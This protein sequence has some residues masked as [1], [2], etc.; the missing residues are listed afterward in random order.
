MTHPY[1]NPAYAQNERDRDEIR[2]HN[3]NP[4][5]VGVL[6]KLRLPKMVSKYVPHQGERE[7]ARRQRQ[8]AR[9][10]A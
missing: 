1:E 8:E 2:R 4:A 9:N 10:G 3:S 7:I 5:A 6:G